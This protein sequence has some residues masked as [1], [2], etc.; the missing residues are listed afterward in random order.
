MLLATKSVPKK[1]VFVKWMSYPSFITLLL[2]ILT[3]WYKTYKQQAKRVEL[4]RSSLSLYHLRQA[5]H[6]ALL[7]PPPSPSSTEFSFASGKV[8]AR[9][10]KWSTK[11]MEGVMSAAGIKRKM[12]IS[13]KNTVLWNPSRDVNTPNHAFHENTIPLLVRWSSAFDI[14]VIAHTTT[15]QDKHQIETL[16]NNSNLFNFIDSRKVLY[17]SS[18]QGKLHLIKQIEPSV[19]IEGGWELEDGSDIVQRLEDTRVIW[20]LPNQKKRELYQHFD[21]EITDHVLNT[22]LA[23]I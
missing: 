22:S 6:Q 5:S 13:L 14:Y 21:M 20:I 8:S 4:K 12:T 16:L 19:H 11:L 17:C 3:Y 7:T 1:W 2:S 10:S 15:P 18:E 23:R 9:G